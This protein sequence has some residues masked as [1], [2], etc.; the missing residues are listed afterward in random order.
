MTTVP[1]CEIVGFT[2]AVVL[3]CYNEAKNLPQVLD[4]LPGFIDEVILV[5]GFSTDGSVAC[6]RGLRPDIKVVHQPAP[7]KGLAMVRGMLAATS[8]VV[9]FLDAD[10]S[11]R[12]EEIFLFTEALAQ[13]AELARGSRRRPGGGSSDFTWLRAAGN[14]LLTWL[15]NGLYGTHWTDLAYG[16]FAIRTDVA[17]TLDL[18]SLVLAADSPSSPR[19]PKLFGPLPYGHGFEIESLVFCRAAKRGVTIA[20]VPSF[21]DKRRHGTSHLH[22]FRDG[23]RV[24]YTILHEKFTSDVDSREYARA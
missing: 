18:E 8:D 4:S 11:M 9:V 24:A 6:A 14:F 20:E 1:E 10:G 16:Y 5:D 2:T 15:V 19:K 7:G 22:A 21:E 12:G 23:L 13:G 17:M 3:P